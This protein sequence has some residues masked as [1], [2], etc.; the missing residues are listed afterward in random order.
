MNQVDFYLIS[1]HVK[2]GQFKLASRLCNKLHRL[3]KTA[4][5]LVSDD[6][7]ANALDEMM[8][9]FSDTSFLPH[10][11][12]SIDSQTE[13][14]Q[15]QGNEVLIANTQ[16]YIH[17]AESLTSQKTDV[18]VNLDSQIPD[19]HQQFARIAEIVAPDESSKQL[20]RARFK[21]YRELGY[22]LETHNIEL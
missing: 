19:K 7:Q 18:L 12:L 5:V 10:S 6:S 1:N 2:D 17:N 16:T 22:T 4:L 14:N 11:I 9:S 13:G 3:Q 8:W 15:V 20:A 21:Q